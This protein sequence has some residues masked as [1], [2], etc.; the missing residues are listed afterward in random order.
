MEEKEMSDNTVVAEVRPL[1]GLPRLGSPAPQFEAPT[2]HGTLRLS[3]FKGSWL[4]LFSHPADFTPVC[5]TEFIA[6]S[7]IYEEL[8]KR[9]T[10]LLGLSVDSVSS[11]IAWIRNVEEKMGVKI[12]RQY[13]LLGTYDFVNILEAPDTQTI[14]RVAMELGSRGALNTTTH[15]AM[16][17]DEFINAMK[18]KK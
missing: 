10:Q 14:A 4:I 2:T 13:A 16:S 17:I 12:L 5:T 11:H 6:F 18:K 1:E 3:D 15:A 7:Q 8:Q 9:N